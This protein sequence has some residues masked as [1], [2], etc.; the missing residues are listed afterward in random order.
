MMFMTSAEVNF[1]TFKGW[2]AGARP[3]KYAPA[4]T[5]ILAVLA[6]QTAKPA[7]KAS[8]QPLPPSV[9]VPGTIREYTSFVFRLPGRLILE[10]A[11]MQ[12][13]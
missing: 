5:D 13:F 7:V 12:T 3:P 11:S 1:F 6:V 2:G 10:P 9:T 4:V 8:D